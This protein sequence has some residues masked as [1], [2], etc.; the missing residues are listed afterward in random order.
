MLIV[1]LTDVHVL[2]AESL[3]ADFCSRRLEAIQDVPSSPVHHVFL[4]GQSWCDS[5]VKFT[6]CSSPY[7]VTAPLSLLMPSRIQ[8]VGIQPMITHHNGSLMIRPLV[9]WC[10]KTGLWWHQ[11]WV[12][13]RGQVGAKKQPADPGRQPWPGRRWYGGNRWRHRPSWPWWRPWRSSWSW[14]RVEEPRNAAVLGNICRTGTNN[15]S[16]WSEMC[17]TA[18]VDKRPQRDETE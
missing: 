6:S 14:S 15:T 12:P 7:S 1:R 9:C 3:P 16:T 2:S 11:G 18:N 8:G 10:L 4:T 17:Y 5:S 13:L